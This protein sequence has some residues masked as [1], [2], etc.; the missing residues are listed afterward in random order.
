MAGGK[1]VNWKRKGVDGTT[2]GVLLHLSRQAKPKVLAY[3]IIHHFYSL[4]KMLP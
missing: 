1:L 4:F 3:S 2:R